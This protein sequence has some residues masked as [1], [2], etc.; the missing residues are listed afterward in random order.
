MRQINQTMRTYSYPYLS[1]PCCCH[2]SSGTIN[3]CLAGMLL[4]TQFYNE[5]VEPFKSKLLFSLDID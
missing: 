3:V 5:N 2:L 1:L 4:S